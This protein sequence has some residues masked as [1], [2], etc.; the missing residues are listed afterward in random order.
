[1]EFLKE[2][3][4]QLWA[5]KKF[6]DLLSNVSE[7]DWKKILPEF[8]KSLQSIYIHKYEVMYAW[9][10]LIHVKDSIKIGDN[11]LKIEDFDQLSKD[12]FIKEAIKLFE[13]IIEYIRDNPDTKTTLT[14]TWIKK[15]Y[16]VTVH[17]VLYNILNHLAYHRGQTA[18][19][20]RKLG[21]ETPETDY[22]P[23]MYELNKLQ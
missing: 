21:L 23:Y 9:F 18:F 10:T 13:M 20:F 7:E 2:S 12:Q 16:V 22:N 11:P 15:P 4:Y 14:V 19:F 1:M 8:N 17:E 3:N 5:E 6:F